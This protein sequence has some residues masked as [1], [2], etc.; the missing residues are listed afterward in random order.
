[1]NAAAQQNLRKLLLRK[2][3]RETFL[4]R[5]IVS[6][7]LEIKEAWQE[8]LKAP[9]FHKIKMGEYFV[10]L[11]KKFTQE[12]RGSAVDVDIFAN[13]VNSGTQAE[14]M[15][16][17]L[18]KLRRTPHTVHTLE[19]THHAAVRAMLDHGEH[20]N[21]VKML[22]DRLNYGVFFDEYSAILTLNKLLGGGEYKAA[23]R[24]SSQL[25]L[26]EQ[27]FSLPSALG[28]LSCWKY[29]SSGREDPWFY[30]E[31]I[32]VD[33]NPEDVV[34][35]RVRDVPN[36]YKDD[37]F[38]LRDPD[39]IL[40]KTLIFFNRDSGD[41]AERSLLMLGHFLFGD[42]EVVVKMLGE[43]EVAQSVLQAIQVSENP[44]VKA[45]AEAATSVELDLSRI[46]ED[47]CKTLGDSVASD[48]AE[49]QKKT[50]QQWNLERDQELQRQ[51]ELMQRNARIESISQTKADLAK[52]EEQLFFFD[53]FDRYEME[54]EE[55]KISWLRT[56]PRRDWRLSA[57]PMKKKPPTA[58]GERKVAR[59]EKREQKTGPPK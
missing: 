8:R 38:D 57:T 18:F 1:M 32:E 53:N 50:Y 11:D 42:M 15:E 24:C 28:N 23:A 54:K 40:G 36:N 44:D 19:S 55:K 6:Q 5:S 16:E 45:A 31:E 33:E 14:H 56:M 10:T 17:L 13:N 58:D 21:L 4:S 41:T 48:L 47:K 34:R 27:N 52:T 39:R 46:L 9:V 29:Y 49:G 59:W 26:Q 35:I 30:P 51:Y 7:N 20:T 25:M 12:Y 2:K 3:W 37:H 43:G 22:D